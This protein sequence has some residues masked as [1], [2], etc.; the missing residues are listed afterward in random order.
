LAVSFSTDISGAIEFTLTKTRNPFAAST[1][2]DLN[3]ISRICQPINE[4]GLTN[5]EEYDG[6]HTPAGADSNI[7]TFTNQAAQP[8]WIFIK[9][10]K[11]IGIRFRLNNG[12]E[13]LDRITITNFMFMHIPT[14][15]GVTFLNQIQFSSANCTNNSDIEIGTPLT[16]YIAAGR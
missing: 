15:D 13:V 8:K 12:S 16:Y 3:C 6:V 1:E 9:V 4:S 7:I 10:S 5:F 14:F 2:V 11:P